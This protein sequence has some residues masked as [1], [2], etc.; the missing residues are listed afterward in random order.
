MADLDDVALFVQISDAGGLAAAE[1]TT[2]LPRSTLS[3]RLSRLEQRLGVQLAKR[4]PQAFA[5][6]PQG[7]TYR[8]S[9][10]AALDG[11][12]QAEAVLK[13]A[14]AEPV[15]IVRLT[16]TGA[17]THGF[18]IDAL[19]SFLQAHPDIGVTM[20]VSG[21][22]VDLASEPFDIALRIGDV[23]GDGQFA[24]ILFEEREGIYASAEYLA[25]SGPLLS[26]SDLTGRLAVS[27]RRHAPAGFP[28]SFRLTNG[29]REATV[30]LPVRVRVNDVVAGRILAERGV[31]VASLPRFIG[32]PAVESGLLVRCLPEWL[33]PPIVVR[34]VLPQKPTAAA[35]VLLE[36]L[37][38]LAKLRW[39][40]PTR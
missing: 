22:K 8:E 7:Q 28:L 17:L 21:D 3:R 36:H 20:D 9:C 33:S 1:A 39:P 31:G 29:A 26:P 40:K 19:P 18:L 6:T 23:L 11:I 4:S 32:D 25:G 12:A 35:R 30:T 13:A 2:G 37:A 15:G 16:T 10:V 14:Q 34:A 38:S 24:R 5:L 27:C